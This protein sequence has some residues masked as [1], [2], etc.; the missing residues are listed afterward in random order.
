M[1]WV[2]LFIRAP[3]RL[4]TVD[5]HAYL[6]RRDA[7]SRESAHRQQAAELRDEASRLMATA[8]GEELLANMYAERARR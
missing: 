5:E 7:M 8:A 6:R 3:L 2:P 1:K 4:I